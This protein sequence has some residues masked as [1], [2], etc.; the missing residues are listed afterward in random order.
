MNEPASTTAEERALL[1]ADFEAS[2]HFTNGPECRRYGDMSLR[3]LAERDRLEA[4]VARLR[5]A[6]GMI[7][8]TSAYHARP[9]VER[10]RLIH[11]ISLAQLDATA[12]E[13]TK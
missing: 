6:M 2:A 7:M 4:E 8:V 11:G 10:L 9:R 12:R 5:E 13:P 3:L 1:L